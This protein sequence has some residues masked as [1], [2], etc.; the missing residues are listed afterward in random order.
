MYQVNLILAKRQSIRVSYVLTSLISLTKTL[1]CGSFM[2]MLR[3]GGV[4][5]TRWLIRPLL[6]HQVNRVRKF[7]LQARELMSLLQFL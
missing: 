3:T 6:C 1:I 7:Q 5:M 2:V 4:K